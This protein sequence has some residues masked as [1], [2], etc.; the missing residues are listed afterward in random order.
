MA[1]VPPISD[2]RFDPNADAYPAK[3][4]RSA[5]ANCLIGCLVVLAVLFVIA[6]IVAYWVST[7][8]RGWAADF[9]SMTVK[10]MIA[11]SGLPAQEQADI[12]IQV[13]RLTTAFRDNRISMEQSGRLIENLVKSPLMTSFMVTAIEKSYFAKSGLSE[14]EKAEGR[15]T[16]QRFMRGMIDEKIPK[17][18][19][20]NAMQHVATK[21][22]RDNWQVK[23]TITDA[24]LRAFLTAAKTEADNAD[25]PAEPPEFDPSDEFTRIVDEALAEPGVQPEAPPALPNE[26]AEPNQ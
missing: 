23:Q 22:A 17:Q 19:I 9:G 2:P 18:G 15:I 13:D 20:E 3:P 8:W 4:K 7:Q 5:W 6:L 26:S 24:E 14:E 1:T 21:D 11:E 12:N 25:I 16:L 10:Q